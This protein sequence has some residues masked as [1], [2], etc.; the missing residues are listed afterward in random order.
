MTTTSESAASPVISR[1]A[2][3]NDGTTLRYTVTGEGP[4]DI[5]LCDGIGCSGFI[6]RFLAPHLREGARVLHPHMRG[7]GDSDAPM[8]PLA[9]SIAG[10]ADDQALIL[11]QEGVESA[12]VLGHSMGV[13]VALELWY[14]H[15]HRVKGLILIC[16]SYENPVA[17]FHN[18][19]ALNKMMPWI[20]LLAPRV[21]KPLKA[22]WQT[23]LPT[24]LS[25]KFALATEIDGDRVDR[26]DVMRY[27]RDLSQID[28]VVFLHMLG[29]A[30][31]HSAAAYLGQIDVPV[32]VIAGDQDKFTPAW[33]SR[34]MAQRIP[35]ST[36]HEI[37]GGTHTAPVEQPELFEQLI[38]TFM[39]DVERAGQGIEA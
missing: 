22:F 20:R 6:W 8:D 2:K 3:A 30:E 4:I 36:Y 16:G 12:W 33:L 27:L 18:Q 26:D 19:G 7:H 5:L 9:Y 32:M 31:G 25:L 37:E 24:E 10:V 15:R 17:T 39:G 1:S 23:M 34:Q 13:Q 14:R 11:D 21:H 28:P 29:G 35:T 38:D